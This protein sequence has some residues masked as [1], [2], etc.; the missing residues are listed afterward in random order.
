MLTRRDFAILSLVPLIG[1]SGAAAAE[2]GLGALGAAFAKIESENGGRLGVAVLDTGSGALTGHRIDERFPL[3]STFKAL[4]AAAI[5]A[6]VDAGK[7]QLSRRI[8]VEQKDILAYAPVT[9]QHVGQDMSVG[10]LCDA[11]V[12][13]SDNTA[14]NLLLASM[15]GPSAITELARSLGDEL[16]RLDRIETELNEGTPGDPRDTTTPA[17]MAKNLKTLTLGTVLS[18]TSR[19]QLIA[20]LVGCKTG[21]TKIRAGLPKGWRVG[22]KTGSGGHGSSNDVAVI[23]PEGRPPVIVASYLTETTGTDDQRNAVHA[24]VGRALAAALAG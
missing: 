20:W 18:A 14:A 8:R 7:E 16:T 4:A 17:A 24:A 12:T 22:D 19:D 15:G 3:C 5:L 6:R 13:L 11:A 21:D 10:E 1:V 23:W 2:G 9:R